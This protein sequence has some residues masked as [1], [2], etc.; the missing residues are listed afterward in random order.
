MLR[1]LVKKTPH[2][3]TTISDKKIYN[4]LRITRL[5]AKREITVNYN[6]ISNCLYMTEG[7]NLAIASIQNSNLPRIG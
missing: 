3:V 5:Y 1:Y 7:T 2:S 6:K 4:A